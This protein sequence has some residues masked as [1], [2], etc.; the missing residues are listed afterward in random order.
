MAHRIQQDRFDAVLFDLDGVL[1]STAKLHA[2]AW[3]ETFDRFLRARAEATGETFRTFDIVTDY[4]RHVDGRLR[5]D[6]VRD[7]LA[8]RDIVL[9]LGKMG[10]APGF[11]T[12]HAVGNLKNLRFHELLQR[13]GVEVFGGSLRLLHFLRGCG[14]KT[15]VVTASRNGGAILEAAHM[16]ELFDA[17]VDGVVAA[18]LGL[19]GKPAPDSFLKA[20]ELLQ[21]PPARA[22]V[23]E[24]ALSGVMAGKRGGFGL[25]IGVDRKDH[26]EELRAHGADWVVRDLSELLED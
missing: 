11:E 6:G 24:D 14:M 16:Q 9:P 2:A 21:V 15:A 17:R 12:L 18:E 4:A 22:V 1:T 19:P 20:A 25:V 5:Q 23:V 10:D 3:K 13:G 26:A 7:F 8:S